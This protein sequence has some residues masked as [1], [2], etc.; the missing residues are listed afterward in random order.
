MSNPFGRTAILL[1]VF[2]SNTSKLNFICHSGKKVTPLASY[3]YP[4]NG[5]TQQVCSF[6]GNISQTASSSVLNFKVSTSSFSTN[7]IDFEQ[8]EL[9]FLPYITNNKKAYK[10]YTNLSGFFRNLLE[11]TI[12]KCV[13]TITDNQSFNINAESYFTLNKE[14]NYKLIFKA[15]KTEL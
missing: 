4:T 3:L 2:N 11:P 5:Y 1:P 9:N 6:W 10:S 14:A 13:T 7:S 12:S 8:Q 15:S